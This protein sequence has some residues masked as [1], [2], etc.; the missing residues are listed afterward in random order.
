MNCEEIHKK[1]DEAVY[2]SPDL[3]PSDIERHIESC[4]LCTEYVDTAKAEVAL[5][6]SLR[7]HKPELQK[8]EEMVL[9]II[10]SI[11]QDSAD[12]KAERE[13]FN[14]LPKLLAAACIALMITFGVE[15]YVVLDKMNK[16][17]NHLSGNFVQQSEKSIQIAG[18]ATSL[19]S[20]GNLSDT[21]SSGTSLIRQWKTKWEEMKEAKKRTHNKSDIQT[22]YSSLFT[23]K[24]KK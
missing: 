17:E 2:A 7:Q 22:D 11:A 23:K 13:R 20:G 5:L 15:Q 8:S 16:L 4:E 1:I 12:N 24:T 21:T 9:E 6:N 14:W 3:M 18:Y 10:A 19:V